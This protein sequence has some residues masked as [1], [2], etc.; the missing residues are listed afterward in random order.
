V[1]QHGKYINFIYIFEV[2]ELT[3]HQQ[4]N[5]SDTTNLQELLV[6]DGIEETTFTKWKKM[7]RISIIAKELT[8]VEFPEK[9][10]WNVCYKLWMPRKALEE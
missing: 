4:V 8:Y 6:K 2:S 7:N 1:K 5:L 3:R 9:F 10:V